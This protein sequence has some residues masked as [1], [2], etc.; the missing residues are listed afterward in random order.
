MQLHINRTDHKM[1]KAEEEAQYSSNVKV[2][3]ISEIYEMSA[4]V[5]FV[6]LGQN[7]FSQTVTLDQAVTQIHITVVKW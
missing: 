5:Y 4:S 2:T 7:S 6:L 3:A 1:Y